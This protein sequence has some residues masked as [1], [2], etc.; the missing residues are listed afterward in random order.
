VAMAGRS[1]CY[2][3]NWVV[4]TLAAN[5]LSLRLTPSPWLAAIV[6]GI[7]LAAYDFFIEPVAIKLDYW[8][9]ADPTI[10]VQNYLAWAVIAAL[11]SLPLQLLKIRFRSPVLIIYFF[12]QL[13]FFLVLNIGL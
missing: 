13:F 10:P 1:F 4:L 9:W 5:E 6:A 12:A 3:T 2:C 8:Q 11:I 7:F